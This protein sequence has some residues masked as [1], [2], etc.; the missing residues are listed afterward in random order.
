MNP[1][2]KQH[3]KYFLSLQFL[4]TFLLAS[5][6][7]FLGTTMG[8][9]EEP[10]Y[11]GQLVFGAENDF[12]GFDAIKNRG[13][14]IIDAIANNTIQERLF[15]LDEN[16]N[17]IPILGLSATPS[18]DQTS[19]IIPLRQ[20]VVF[21]DG[22]PFNA[23]AVLRHWHRILDPKN[24]YRGLALLKPIK[25]VEK[26]DDFTIQFN[27]HHAWLAFPKI[28]AGARGLGSFIPSPKAVAEDTQQR[29]PVGTGPFMFKEWKSGNSFT[30]QKNPN[31]WQK[32]KP[33][34]EEIIFK[35]IPDHQARYASLRAGQLDITWMDRGNIINKAKKD[36]SL[37]HHQTTGNGAEIFVLNTT[38]PPFNDPM[39]RRAF[40]HAWNQKVCVNMSYKDAIPFVSHPLGNTIQCEDVAYPIH[41]VAKA[42]ELLNQSEKIPEVECLHS[43]T[44]RGREQ[45]E[46]LQQLAKNAGFTVN[47]KGLSFGPVIKKVYTK[48][49]QISTWRIPT[50]TDIG[51][52]LYTTFY[53][54]SRHNVMGYSNIELDGLLEAQRIETDPEKRQKLHCDIARIINEDVPIIFR[55]G[56]GYNILAGEH[57]KG[58]TDFKNGIARL[59]DIWI[60]K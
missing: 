60:D 37:V 34:L 54:K 19:W 36:Q 15:G 43:D 28:L 5:T 55:G 53:S 9:S 45:G 23:E 56:Q 44:K 35:M 58:F 13:F 12:I 52:S 41:S 24:R 11:G 21:H 25:S 38:K 32:D 7:I 33:Y 48:D 22:I 59:S 30:V 1:F 3:F 42:R 27:L 20:G 50:R 10:K 49:Y 46:L 4:I 57:V 40:A 31:Y 18:D 17:L 47:T 2:I 8:Q 14:P 51:T 39:V 6:F 16:E 26:I 29:S